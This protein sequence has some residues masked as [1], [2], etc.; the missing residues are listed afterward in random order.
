MPW[1]NG[2]P[3]L[4]TVWRG[5]LHRCYNPKAKQFKDYGGRGIKVCPEWRDNFRQFAADMT[6]RPIGYT[7]DRIDNDKG[8]SPKNCKW[9]TR[10][11]QQRNQ[12]RTHVVTIEGKKYKAIELAELTG[13][14]CDTILARVRR[15]RPYKEVI[16]KKYFRDLEHLKLGAAISG[17]KRRARTHCKFGHEYTDENTRWFKEGKYDIRGCRACHNDKMRRRYAARRAGLL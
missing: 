12:R 10:K 5:M 4:Y 2:N 9:S 11:E 15:G 6:P 3:P 7:L 16:S 17:A 8:Y 14:K 1:K 13:L